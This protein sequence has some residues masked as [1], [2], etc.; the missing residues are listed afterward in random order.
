MPEA[1]PFRGAS[2]ALRALPAT[3]GGAALL[4]H[5]FSSRISIARR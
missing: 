4:V 5:P 1:E 2:A 3:R